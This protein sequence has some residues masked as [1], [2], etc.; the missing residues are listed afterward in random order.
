MGIYT[1]QS[2]RAVTAAGQCL[3]LSGCLHPDRI[4]PEHDL[5][6][7]LE[8]SWEIWQNGTRYTPLA[9]D[10]IILHAGQH[11]FGRIPCEPH[12]R[13]LFIHVKNDIGDCFE[14]NTLEDTQVL[15][16]TV[17]HCPSND[18]VAELFKTV[19]RLFE[20]EDPRK[21]QRLS[22]VVRLLLMELA[23]SRGGSPNHRL[24]REALTVMQESPDKMFRSEE[25]ASR[26][27]VS[28]RTVRNKF[29]ETF[30]RSFTQY[31]LETKLEKACLMLRTY[32]DMRIREIADSLGFY[33]EFH[34]SKVFK[35][36]YGL[37]PSR[38]RKDIQ[39]RP[40]AETGE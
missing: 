12:T 37:S 38:Y 2:E 39:P 17:I 40:P 32:P 34:F 23:D 4:M 22:C 6:Y 29:R 35:K 14:E 18:R 1:I 25:I 11:H 10:V 7:I 20:S 28:A 13:T 9:G 21:D 26:L 15:L 27:Y 19:I 30:H 5:V 16:P 24:I 31:Q 3:F 8:G 36:H 33:D